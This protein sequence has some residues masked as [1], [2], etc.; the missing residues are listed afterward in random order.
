M[1]KK[2]RKF[3]CAG[4]KLKDVMINLR[5]MASQEGGKF[6]TIDI[7]NVRDEDATVPE[8]FYHC[9]SAMASVRDVTVI[10]LAHA[11]GDK[12]LSSLGAN[13]R[14]TSLW[15]TGVVPISQACLQMLSPNV[16]QLT[17]P[18]S[19]ELTFERFHSV[20]SLTLYL[21]DELELTS[22]SSASMPRVE[23]LR[24]DNGHLTSS[25]LKALGR[26]CRLRTLELQTTDVSRC[27]T[28][29]TDLSDIINLRRLVLA[30]LPAQIGA[31]E[32]KR[33]IGLKAL[34]LSGVTD[35]DR[36]E[37][38]GDL[39]SLRTLSISLE[40]EIEDSRKF[41][42]LVRGLRSKLPQCNV[43]CSWFI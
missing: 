3:S 31:N 42:Q 39:S 4:L 18:L 20:Q 35:I 6:R 26:N 25:F 43:V 7:S 9:L 30:D 11:E 34:H 17:V 28:L 41:K 19:T 14:L 38:L 23:Y 22:R 24:V 8:D 27:D 33:L 13:R 29:L 1:G 2:K 36:L 12:I 40:N 5:H 15:M 37:M 21:E 10:G 32:L 16:L